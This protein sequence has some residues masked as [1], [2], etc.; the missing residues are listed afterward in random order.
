M[1]PD[2]RVS[3]VVLTHNR[4]HELARTLRE[5]GA[6]PEQ[7]ALIVVDNGSRAGTV[8][9]V[10][11]D[12]PRVQCVRCED[13]RGAAGRNAGVAQVDTPYV[14]FCD[15]DTWW[16]PDALSR[17]ADLLD[18]HPAVGALSARVLVGEAQ[19]L[20]PTCEAMAHSPLD[21]TGLPGPALISFMA[22]AAVMRTVAYRDVGGYEPR[23]FLGA[24]EWLMGLDLAARGWRMVYASEV[25]TH[26]HPSPASRDAAAR[27]IVQARN[28]LWIA[29]MR[30]PL[31][32]AWRESRRVLA[33]AGRLGLM[34][35]ALRAAL[36]GLPWAL[37]R[38][39]V[40]P[41]RVHEMYRQ[42]SEVTP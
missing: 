3:V 11:A 9:R 15:D 40:L 6:L 22:G 29:W 32:S 18:A 41:A 21:S 28:R 8:D 23:L 33:E 34:R 20:D 36:A 4:P 2:P 26:H 17:A 14:A 19:R 31:A 30:L 37:R 10:V 5:L 35:P 38:R 39:S 24:E 16:A 42:V 25:V 7:P 27:R 12:F 1:S 13:N